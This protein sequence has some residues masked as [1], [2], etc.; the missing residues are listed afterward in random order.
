MTITGP[1]SLLLYF[2][3]MGP[4][5]LYT[6]YYVLICIVG[7]LNQIILSRVIIIKNLV[8]GAVYRYL[9]QTIIIYIFNPK[10]G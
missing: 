2:E 5:Y 1:I 9:L 10:Y 4:R 3:Q 6:L 8:Q 7:H